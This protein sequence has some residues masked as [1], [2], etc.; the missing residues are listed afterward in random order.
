[1]SVRDDRRS[2]QDRSNVVLVTVDCWRDDAIDHMDRFSHYVSETGLSRGTAGCHAA[3]TA[4]SFPSILSGQY[5]HSV[6]ETPREEGIRDDNENRNVTVRDGVESLPRILSREGY[7]TAAFV[8]YN[9]NVDMW[10]PYFDTWKNGPRE[11][12]PGS[13][14]LPPALNT[15]IHMTLQ[16]KKAPADRLVDEALDWIASTGDRSPTFAWIHLMEPHSPYYAGLS[17]AYSKGLVTTYRA[18]WRH[19]LTDRKELLSWSGYDEHISH[20]EEMYHST[21]ETLDRSLVRLLE[22]LPP[23]T[24]VFI[25]GDHGEEFSDEWYGHSRPYDDV[26]RVPL[27]TN[28]PID[29]DGQ[30]RHVEVPNMILERN[31]IEPPETWRRTL[32]Y[33]EEYSFVVHPSIYNYEQLFVGVR[34]RDYHYLQLRSPDTA[35][36]EAEEL[37]EGT[38]AVTE[39][40]DV[41]GKMSGTTEELRGITEQFVDDF[42]VDLTEYTSGKE[43]PTEVSD[44]LRE[45]GYLS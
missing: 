11:L 39:K 9:P 26:T 16:R 36:L 18:S 25:T 28:A 41:S 38:S 13:N 23:D 3:A 45:L 17:N 22:R 37:Y 6:L 34:S 5:F 32:E 30:V 44:R 35:E 20:I 1:M 10:A 42:D 33:R 2:S 43:P 15:L 4:W 29:Q 24:D 8:G 40:E 12:F 27:V 14:S 19:R 7:E 21:L 31:A